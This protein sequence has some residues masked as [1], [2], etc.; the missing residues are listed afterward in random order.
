MT[1]TISDKFG[2]G[3]IAQV[4][5]VVNDM[6]KALEFYGALYGPFE[7]YTAELQD[8]SI[9]GQRGDC[10]LHVAT[11]NAGPV[12]VELIAVLDGQPPH[13]DHLRDHGE[14]LHHVRFN[15]IAIDEK[16]EAMEK[17]GF[18][19]IFYKK[20]SPEIR[21]AYLQAPSEMGGHVVELLEM[22]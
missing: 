12:E 22:P 18:E 21:F 19:V 14:G 11:N 17:S 6:E 9:R 7:S 10:T 8:C 15:V 20:Y 5:Y 4:A 2:L 13:S 1:Q 16:I 3:S